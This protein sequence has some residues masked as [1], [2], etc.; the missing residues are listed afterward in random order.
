[1]PSPYRT[2]ISVLC[3]LALVLSLAS[4]PVVGIPYQRDKSSDG[5][6]D[7]NAPVRVYLGE[8]GLNVSAV[9]TTSGQRVGSGSV[10]ITGIKGDADGTLTQ[11][12]GDSFDFTTGNDV[13]TGGYDVDDDDQVDFSVVQPMITSTTL[14]RTPGATPS[15]SGVDGSDISIRPGDNVTVEV[16]Y[17]FDDASWTFIEVKDNENIDITSDVTSSTRVLNSGDTILLD[18]SNLDPGNY[19]VPV[20]SKGFGPSQSLYFEIKDETSELSLNSTSVPVGSDVLMTM[21]GV[22]GETVNVSVPRSAVASDTRPSVDAIFEPVGSRVAAGYDARTEQFWASYEIDADGTVQGRLLTDR[23]EADKQISVELRGPDTTLAESATS[24]VDLS[25]EELQLSVSH[26]ERVAMGQSMQIVGSVPEA[27][28][29]AAYIRVDGTWQL[30]EGSN[31]DPSAT[32]VNSTGRF[33]VD[34][35]VSRTIDIAEPYSIGVRVIDSAS[36]PPASFETSTFSDDVH[37]IGTID[38]TTGALTASVSPSRIPTDGSVELMIS[39]TATGTDDAV[40]AYVVG[41]RGAVDYTATDVDGSGEFSA[42]FPNDFDRLVGGGD[43]SADLEGTYTVLVISA[44]NDQVF[45]EADGGSVPKANGLPDEQLALIRDAYSSAGSDDSVS[46][47]TFEA[48][49]ASLTIQSISDSPTATQPITISGVSTYDA[50]FEV[51]VVVTNESGSEVTSTTAS[52]AQDTNQWEATVNV[53]SPGEYRVRA[54]ESGHETTRRLSVTAPPETST[55]ADTPV[56]T[57]TPVSTDE[58]VPSTEVST[59]ENIGSPDAPGDSGPN[60]P[61]YTPIFAALGL[62]IVSIVAIS[63][64][65]D[66]W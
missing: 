6:G 60:S 15:T 30:L 8:K 37:A 36:T 43:A 16:G 10:A 21:T 3:V 7:A 27:D 55:P 1:M 62:F 44:G 19:R 39:G 50:P 52:V 56:S 31:G 58:S 25:I 61:N 41:P 14:Y 57:A 17:N 4:A 20:K 48:A 29:V 34:A 54:M 5:V 18:T 47:Q 33:A 59:P 12:E 49:G 63:W 38:V 24:E 46:T 40:R 45:A 23:F 66:L 26:P 42:E 32:D 13:T 2:W 22:S 11:G 35:D 64:W 65:R 51:T 28:A 53:S 9:T